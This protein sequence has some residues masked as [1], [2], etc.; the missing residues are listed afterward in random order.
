MQVDVSKEDDVKRMV[1]DT[2]AEHGKLDV[3]V[4]V[5][6]IV[7]FTP[8]DE[9][10]FAEWRRV[11]SVNLDGTF[12][13]NYYAQKAMRENGYGRIVN[14]ASNVI[15]AGTPNLAHYV[16]SKGG[17]WAFTRALA[18]EL[19]PHGD[20]GQR[21][22]AGS[23][24][25]RGRAGEQ[26]RGGIRVRPDAPGDPA[27]C[28]RRRHRAGGRVPRVRGGGLGDRPADRRGRRAHAQLMATRA[29]AILAVADVERSVAFYRDH[30]G[31]EVEALYDDPPYATLALAGARLSLAEQGHAAEDRPGVDLTAPADPSRA[32]VVLVVEVDDARA[33][34]RRLA[35]AGVRF[36]AEPFEP[37]WGGCRFFC[38]DPDGYLV[39]I[40]QPA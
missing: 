7:P 22:R 17:V 39:E 5:A 27:P 6:A 21:R 10:D 23:D 3:L 38:V 2:V 34:H 11:M 32:D 12:L 15:L 19:G 20:H 31:F 26:A 4:N 9:V 1:A 25:D 18:R 13:T 14:I 30:I 37:P 24:R 8:W 16:A 29:G 36:L 28:G 40:E 33:E 35:G